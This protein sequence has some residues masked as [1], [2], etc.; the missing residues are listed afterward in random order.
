[1][2]ILRLITKPFEWIGIGLIYFYKYCISPLL[3][4]GCIYQPSCSTYTLVCIKRFGIFKGCWLGAKR[5]LRCTPKHK[6]GLDVPPDNIKGDFKW[7][8]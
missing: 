7:L 2:N 4:H 3:P 6:G 5:I 1:M 8:I